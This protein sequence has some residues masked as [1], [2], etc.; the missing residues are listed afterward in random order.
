MTDKRHRDG[1]TVREAAQAVR[2]SYAN[3]NRI[4][5]GGST[6]ARNLLPLLEWLGITLASIETPIATNASAKPSTSKTRGAARKIGFRVHLRAARNLDPKT[7]AALAEAFRC[8]VR[9][10]EQGMS[11][12]KKP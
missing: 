3:F 7:A 4:E 8:V 1:L 2:M 11:G 12:R 6:S 10:L 9:V 5:N